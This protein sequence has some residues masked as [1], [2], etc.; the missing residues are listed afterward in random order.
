LVI[1]VLPQGIVPVIT[2]A[3]RKL[4]GH[5]SRREI[6]GSARPVLLVPAV[7]SS[8]QAFGSDAVVQ[9]AGLERRRL[10]AVERVA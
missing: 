4:W 2:V 6:A 3:A 7:S 8:R 5:V 10:L 1:V 9:T